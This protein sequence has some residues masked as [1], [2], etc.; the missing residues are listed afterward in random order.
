MKRVL[1]SDK[2]GAALYSFYLAITHGTPYGLEQS[3]ARDAFD[4]IRK[5]A[6]LKVEP[7]DVIQAVG[8]CILATSNALEA[9]RGLKGW[10][11]RTGRH[12]PRARWA[13]S[14]NS[15]A[16]K[17]DRT[18]GRHLSRGLSGHVRAGG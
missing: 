3:F 11:G 13:L 2:L 16:T 18:S 5:I 9:E 12:R 15:P 10:L 17:T 4:P 7:I 14:P 6:P 8:A 1:G